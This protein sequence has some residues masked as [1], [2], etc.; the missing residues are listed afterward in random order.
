MV[1]HV[2]YIEDIRTAGGNSPIGRPGYG[3]GG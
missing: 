2:G 3:W 1:G